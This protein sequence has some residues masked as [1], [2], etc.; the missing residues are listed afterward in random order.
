MVR[1]LGQEVKFLHDLFVS[2]RSHCST[3][4]LLDSARDCMELNASGGEVSR[5]IGRPTWLVY[6]LD[7]LG[8]SVVMIEG[9]MG[10]TTENSDQPGSCHFSDVA[11]VS[12]DLK[13]LMTLLF[14]QQ[15]VQVNNKENIKAQ[16][17]WPFVEG[18]V[19][20]PSQ[21]DSISESISMPQCHF[22]TYRTPSQY[23]DRLIYVWRFP[24]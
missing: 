24:C 15:L 13:L 19:G 21:R 7:L 17:Y 16:H 22:G 9:N 1:F 8:R 6:H 5:T 11:W 2:F 3:N 4:I 20:F 23:K 14:V 12:R 10:F 18:I